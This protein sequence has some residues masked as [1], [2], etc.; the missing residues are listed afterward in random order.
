MSLLRKLLKV[1]DVRDLRSGLSKARDQI[2]NLEKAH[3]K[4][5]T[6]LQLLMG[7]VSEVEERPAV[8]GSPVTALLAKEIESLKVLCG[9]IA[10]QRVRALPASTPLQEVEF[11]VFSQWGED[12]IL[13]FLLA[14]VPIANEVFV[15]FGVE[16]YQEANTR[17]LLLNN[18]WSGCILD[19][20]ESSMAAVMASDLGWRYSLQA[21][22]AWVTA[23]NINDLLSTR[24]IPRDLGILSIDIDGMDYWVWKAITVVQ[25]RI[26]IVEFNSLFGP[27][28]PVTPPYSP[29]FERSSAHFSHVFYGLSLAAVEQLG[30]ER[31]YR[32]IGI[33]QAGNNAFLI[34]EDLA[35]SFPHRSARDLWRPALFR[36]A[37]REDGSLAFPAFGEAQQMIRDCV[38]QDLRNDQ[39]LPLKQVPG[40]L[41]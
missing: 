22:A 11:R 38:V 18:G 2:R 8:S 41:D 9:H 33:N 35:G 20:S 13:Q 6:Q 40:W 28:A 5:E 1:P 23:E 26:M 25:P 15:E 7:K 16:T 17:F 4:K 31:G 37:R 34:R 21:C 14:H 27:V 29:R 12:G 39:L 10:A 3:K 36:E 30:K 24:N 19:G 32:L